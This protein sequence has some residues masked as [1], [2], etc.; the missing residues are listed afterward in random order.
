LEFK[1]DEDIKLKYLA[2]INWTNKVAQTGASVSDM[3]DEY[4]YLYHDYMKHFKLHKLK[5]NNTMLELIVNAGVGV[6]AAFQTGTYLPVI[7]NLLQMNLSQASLDSEESKIPGK[8]VA[9]IY[10]TKQQFEK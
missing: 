10:H 2:L 6:F 3:K 5:Y 9:Y 7:K 1:S 8:E 4:V